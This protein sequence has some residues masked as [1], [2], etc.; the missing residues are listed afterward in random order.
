MWLID[1]IKSFVTRWFI[2]KKEDKFING[3]AIHN[4]FMMR[5]FFSKYHKSGECKDLIMDLKRH[6]D[7]IDTT[8]MFYDKDKKIRNLRAV[9]T[10]LIEK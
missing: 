4:E 9:L 1:L 2:V 3:W 10:V 8:E 7:D 6:I 5:A